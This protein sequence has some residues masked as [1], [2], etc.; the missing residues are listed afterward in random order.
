MQAVLSADRVAWVPLVDGYRPRHSRCNVNL[1]VVV[2]RS[3]CRVGVHENLSDW[4]ICVERA[5]VVGHRMQDRAAVLPTHLFA[6][7]DRHVTRREGVRAGRVY[8]GVSPARAARVGDT[9]RA[10]A[11]YSQCCDNPTDSEHGTHRL[12]PGWPTV[13]IVSWLQY[14]FLHRTRVISQP[15]SYQAWRGCSERDRKAEREVP[16]TL[17]QRCYPNRGL[18][19]LPVFTAGHDGPHDRPNDSPGGKVST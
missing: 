2:E 11:G 19:V 12:L 7:R 10:T 4:Q 1:A 14:R 13:L 8:V 5:P 3:G 9:G 15:M 17:W 18:D 16:T 6:V